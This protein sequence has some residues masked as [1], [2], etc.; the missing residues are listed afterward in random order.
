MKLVERAHQMIQCALV[1]GDMCIDATAGN[2]HDT[3]FLAKCVAPEGRVWSIDIQQSAISK[4]R[5]RI[6][7]SGLSEV[8]SLIHDC[9][10][11]VINHLPDACKGMVAV[12]MFNLGY[13]P[14][15][16]HSVRTSPST[17]I[18][19]LKLIYEI[20]KPGGLLSVLCYRGHTGGSE[21]A[22]AIEKHCQFE[23]WQTERHPGSE[24]P[25]SPLLLV[26][27]KPQNGLTGSTSDS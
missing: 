4:T 17:T 25:S 8:I 27:K 12:A 2:G 6:E 21:E 11:K 26:I 5:K 16:D 22:E 14:G 18:Q 13:L 1:N 19:A 15:S 24:N 7:D 9:H 3:V 10:S 20:L 23:N